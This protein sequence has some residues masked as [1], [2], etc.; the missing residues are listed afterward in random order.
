MKFRVKKKFKLGEVKRYKG[1]AKLSILIRV[2]VHKVKGKGNYLV[3]WLYLTCGYKW[4]T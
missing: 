3:F 4:E 2:K 1:F